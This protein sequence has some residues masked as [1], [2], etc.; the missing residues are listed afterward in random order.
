M[1]LGTVYS[2]EKDTAFLDKI[3]CPHC[4]LE[5]EITLTGI[6]AKYNAICA[7]CESIFEVSILHTPP[8][9]HI[10]TQSRKLPQEYEL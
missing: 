8:N 3:V 9:V 4:K 2:L 10:L 7:R 5:S 1:D 6:S